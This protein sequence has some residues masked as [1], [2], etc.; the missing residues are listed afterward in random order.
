[1]KNFDLSK[2]RWVD[3]MYEVEIYPEEE[4]EKTWAQQLAE[5]ETFHNNLANLWLGGMTYTAIAKMHGMDPKDVSYI[6]KP[7]AKLHH[8]RCADNIEKLNKVL[9]CPDP[10]YMFM[11][12]QRTVL[13]EMCALLIGGNEIKETL[14]QLG[15]LG[16]SK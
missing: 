2:G 7:L 11:V 1:M 15:N 8:E 3:G 10:D 14:E 12:D 4:W 6:C 13:Q 5:T 16:E 9:V